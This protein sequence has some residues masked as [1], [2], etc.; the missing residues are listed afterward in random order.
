EFVSVAE[1]SGLIRP[2][3]RQVLHRACAQLANWRSRGIVADDVSISVNVSG[4]QL[5]E[6]EL[7]EDVS[8][9]LS[10]SRLPA[11][12][13]RLEI[14]ESSIPHDPA[15][16]PALL[17]RLERLGVRAQIDDFGTGYSSL[18]FLR[19]F[20]GDALKIDRSFVSS[21]RQEDGSVEIV[22]A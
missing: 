19:R 13:L 17:D 12:A 8:S 18:S 10:I 3:G 7:V 22:A 5:V 2:L 20:P 11:E 1:D 6:E 14:T 9:A 16:I 21:I 15:R 4:R